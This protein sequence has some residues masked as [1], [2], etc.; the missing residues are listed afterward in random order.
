MP[1]NSHLVPVLPLRTP[2]TPAPAPAPR[3]EGPD[4][5]FSSHPGETAQEAEQAAPPQT[6][7]RRKARGWPAQR[8]PGNGQKL[9]VTI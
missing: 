9:N 4:E 1:K 3:L 7:R 8:D 5:P 6:D 2:A